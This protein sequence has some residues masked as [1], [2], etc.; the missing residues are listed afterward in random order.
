MKKLYWLG[1]LGLL[2]SGCS[3]RYDF[4]ECSSTADCMAFATEGESAACINNECIVVA[5]CERDDDCA[6]NTPRTKCE[7][8]ICVEPTTSTNNDV[9]MDVTEDVTVADMGEDT[10]D[11]DMTIIPAC[12]TNPDCAEGSLCIASECV[13][14]KSQDCDQV[15]IGTEARSPKTI[16]LG[17]VL[18]KA[19]P[20]TNIGPP[21]EKSIRLAVKE[22]NSAGGL[23]DGSRIVLVT[24][25]DVGNA[26]L[27]QRGARHLVEE[28]RS[29]ALIGPLLSTPFIDVVTNVAR[30]SGT[31][32]ISPTASAPEI[33][34]LLDDGLAW[35][36]FPSDVIQANAVV[37]RIKELQAISSRRVTVFYKDDAYGNGLFNQLSAKIPAIVGNNGVQFI[38]YADPA[39]FGFDPTQ[40]ATEF[41]R[42]IGQSTTN[43]G[44][45]LLIIGTSEAIS[46]ALAYYQNVAPTPTLFTHGA[47]ADLATI[48]SINEALQ[49]LVRAL[50]PN[51][52]HPTNYP[53]YLTRFST[54]YPNEPPITISTLTYDA[55]VVALLGMSGVPSGTEITG[56]AI[57]EAMAKIVDKEGTQV[58][59]DDP[60]FF[61]TGR[62]ALAGGGTIDYVGVSGELDFDL[63]TG[64]VRSDYLQFA[65]YKDAQNQWQLIPERAYLL[66]P[67]LFL[68]YWFTLCSALSPSPG[69]CGMTEACI[70]ANAATSLCLS[71]C[72]TADPMCL[73]GL[74]CADL[75]DPTPAG[76][77]VCAPPQ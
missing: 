75:P 41:G 18:S 13:V 40:I 63:T 64:D 1:A 56:T 74:A 49:P 16:V 57:A 5:E 25:D 21:L 29:P 67:N 19:P 76:V 53:T 33:T 77:G 69:M 20:Y 14:M 61:S 39:T 23:P 10:S 68:G 9:G 8:T 58:S 26:T 7:A 32:M 59:Y 34:A 11:A 47:A 51:I 60:T 37:G 55:T 44:N 28:L 50:G 4:T 48:P 3:L 2:I 70:P 30:P 38:K 54:E 45:Y 66:A 31:F 65:T 24:C 62:N 17:A 36:T 43:P 15:V 27:A 46:L 12:I 72:S 22:F 6:A 52:F 73:P 71:T 35:R 42:V